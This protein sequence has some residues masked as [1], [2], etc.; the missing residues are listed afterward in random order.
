MAIPT[1][2]L[3]PSWGASEEFPDVVND[4]PL[5]DG[6]SVNS[7]ASIHPN[8]SVWNISRTGLTK[9]EVDEIAGLLSSWAGVQNF[10][11]SPLPGEVPRILVYC[12]K[13][14]VVPLGLNTFEFSCQLTE[15]ARGECASFASLLDEADISSQI[16]QASAFITAFTGFIGQQINQ[17]LQ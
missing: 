8:T 10:Y 3:S 17:L 14:S 4:T 16:N 2:L 13:W 12:D 15:D 6:Y 1:L 11:W 9:E 5:G 7:P